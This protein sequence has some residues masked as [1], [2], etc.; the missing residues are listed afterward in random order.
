[1]KIKAVNLDKFFANKES[2]YKN[3]MIVSKRA[4]QIIS[5]RYEEQSALDDIEDT[6]EIIEYE[7]REHN[8]EKSISIAMQE[9]LN[10][11]LEYRNIKEESDEQD[12]E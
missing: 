9:L 11:E 4:R 3:I 6:D 7:V 12:T 10:K 5:D 2:I 1:M 8:Q